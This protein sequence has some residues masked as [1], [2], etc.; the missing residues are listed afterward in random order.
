MIVRTELKNSVNNFQ[1]RKKATGR[2]GGVSFDPIQKKY[3]PPIDAKAESE[4]NKSDK[5]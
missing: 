1:T 2:G 3:G 4:G 5:T